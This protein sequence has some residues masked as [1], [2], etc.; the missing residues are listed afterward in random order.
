ML[1]L[2]QPGH[3]LTQ[4]GG[5]LIDGRSHQLFLLFVSAARNNLATILAN[6]FEPLLNAGNVVRN[7]IQRFLQLQRFHG[8]ILDAKLCL[9]EPLLDG[10]DTGQIFGANGSRNFEL[11]RL[12]LHG[13]VQSFRMQFECG[14][15]L[16][17]VGRYQL[18]IGHVLVACR[19][20]QALAVGN[21]AIDARLNALQLGGDTILIRIENVCVGQF[22]Q[23]G[24][25]GVL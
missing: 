21:G 2:V 12:V 4:L 7:T 10:I 8:A 6:T 11:F 17:Y 14:Q 15:L 1:L 23:Q 22:V 24:V 3:H 5:Q 16:G 13:G 18:L 19:L 20:R 9:L 25:D